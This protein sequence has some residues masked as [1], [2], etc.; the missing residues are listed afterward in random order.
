MEAWCEAPSRMGPTPSQQEDWLLVQS[1]WHWWLD[2]L[3][4]LWGPTL[5]TDLPV[6]T[7]NNCKGSVHSGNAQ[8]AKLLTPLQLAGR[9]KTTASSHQSTWSQGSSGTCPLARS[10]AHWWSPFGR[11]HLGGYYLQWKNN[12]S[13]FDVQ[14]THTHTF[15][16][17]PFLGLFRYNARNKREEEGNSIS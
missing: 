1:H 2:E 16:V 13:R 10:L 11:L 6:T 12:D 8:A 5:S 4:R 15:F 17:A 14:D 3:D 7:P 9:A